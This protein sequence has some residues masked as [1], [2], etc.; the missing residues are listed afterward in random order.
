VRGRL[1]APGRLRQLGGKV[2]F[3]R[4]CVSRCRTD[5][6]KRCDR[7]KCSTKRASDDES[8]RSVSDTYAVKAGHGRNYHEERPGNVTK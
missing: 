4:V 8:G 6:T 3:T 7:A 2:G 5:T 1:G